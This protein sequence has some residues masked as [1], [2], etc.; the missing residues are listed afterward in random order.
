MKNLIEITLK[1]STVERVSGNVAA[2]SR[3]IILPI[4]MQRKTS[5]GSF[6]GCNSL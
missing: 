3:D 5:F 4:A 1:L 2:I 6:Y